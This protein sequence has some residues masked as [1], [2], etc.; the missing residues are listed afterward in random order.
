MLGE[1]GGHDR[2]S[3]SHTNQLQVSGISVGENGHEPHGTTATPGMISS[4]TSENHNY[5]NIAL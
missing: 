2:I 5:S 4:V 1:Y 3:V